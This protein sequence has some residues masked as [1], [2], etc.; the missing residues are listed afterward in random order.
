M[1]RTTNPTR[2]GTSTRAMTTPSSLAFS[3][4]GQLTRAQSVGHTQQS[5]TGPAGE[6]DRPY[7]PRRPHQS[8]MGPAA[9]MI[10]PAGAEPQGSYPAG[11]YTF[12]ST[13]QAVGTEPVINAAAFLATLQRT[14][15]EIMGPDV[16]VSFAQI[17]KGT[18]TQERVT[19]RS[20]LYPTGLQRVLPTWWVNVNEI[21]LSSPRPFTLNGVNTQG[22]GVG[23]NRA[24]ARAVAQVTSWRNVMADYPAPRDGGSLD[25]RFRAP[26]ACS[27]GADYTQV[28]ARA[29][30]RPTGQAAPASTQGQGMPAATELNPVTPIASPDA[31]VMTPLGPSANPNAAAKTCTVQLQAASHLRATPTFD[32]GTS[33]SFPVGT[34]V[35]VSGPF[36]AQRGSLTL[37]P[38]VVN[39]RAGFMPLSR[40]EMDACGALTPPASQSS[41]SSGGGHGSSSTHPVAVRSRTVA[42]TPTVAA[43]LAG[44]SS[45]MTYVWIALAV[46]AAFGTTAAIVKRKEI[47]AYFARKHKHKS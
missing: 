45:S 30:T 22:Q 40:A 36:V 4:S 10:R 38:V 14:V 11:S 5:Y 1:N 35:F 24:I 16:S 39:G 21:R 2:G 41:S 43:N 17:V 9:D 3:P 46:V 42:P 12:N 32:I 33:P 19:I 29:C 13:M 25:A 26:D 31:P 28:W 47:R 7:G 27:G 18:M 34:S 20:V 15:R 23:L 37:Y 8:Y 44:D 6:P